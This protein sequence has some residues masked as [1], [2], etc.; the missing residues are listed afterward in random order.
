[1]LAC[2]L[3]LL[4]LDVPLQKTFFTTGAANAERFSTLDP[5]APPRC[6]V[7][8]TDHGHKRCLSKVTS[9]TTLSRSMRKRKH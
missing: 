2:T 3:A 1:M 8:D 5:G 4:T 9:T 7:G 6:T